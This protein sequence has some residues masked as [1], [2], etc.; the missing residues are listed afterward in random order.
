MVAGSLT[1]GTMTD[2]PNPTVREYVQIG[3]QQRANRC[4]ANMVFTVRET[5]AGLEIEAWSRRIHKAEAGQYP[6]LDELFDQ[7][8]YAELVG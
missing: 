7:I 5:P 2:S 8:M 6:D 3:L 1:G 4:K